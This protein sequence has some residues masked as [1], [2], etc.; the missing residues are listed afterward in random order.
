MKHYI[1]KPRGGKTIRML[2]VSEFEGAPIICPD[3]AARRHLVNLSRK[4]DFEIPYPI[5]AREMLAGKMYKSN[6][7]NRFLVDDSKEVLQVLVSCMTHA[8]PE[9]LI[10]LTTNDDRYPRA[11]PAVQHQEVAQ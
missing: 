10:G 6:I 9:C 8:G 5:T 3:E 2:A 11:L 4:Y 7:H 1:L